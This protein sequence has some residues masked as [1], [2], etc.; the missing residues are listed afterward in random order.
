MMNI[1]QMINNF[2]WFYWQFQLIAMIPLMDSFEWWLFHCLFF[3]IVM[4]VVFIFYV[5]VPMQ[6]HL[7][8]ETLCHLFGLQCKSSRPAIMWIFYISQGLCDSVDSFLL[9]YIVEFSK[10]LLE[11]FWDTQIIFFWSMKEILGK[12]APQLHPTSAQKLLICMCKLFDK[13]HVIYKFKFFQRSLC[14]IF[15]G[16]LGASS[17]VHFLLFLYTSCYY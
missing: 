1:K 16:C 8:L 5:I 12:K 6:I 7:A 9:A 3:F 17:D 14:L 2:H 10:Q 4:L 11:T 13:W 15:L